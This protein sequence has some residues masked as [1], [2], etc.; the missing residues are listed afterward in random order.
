MLSYAG[1][2]SQVQV[3]RL[4]LSKLEFLPAQKFADWLPMRYSVVR[5][6]VVCRAMGKHHRRRLNQTID[7]VAQKVSGIIAPV[8]D[9]C[10][11]INTADCP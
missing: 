6:N 7:W 5:P 11:S 8:R 2:T 10:C 1:L 3:V 4:S 9:F